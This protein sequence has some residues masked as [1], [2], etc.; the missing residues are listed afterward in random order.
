MC[1]RRRVVT[2]DAAQRVQ[3]FGRRPF[4]EREDGDTLHGCIITLAGIRQDWQC[5]VV[6]QFAKSFQQSNTRLRRDVAAQRIDNGRRCRRL[7]F[8]AFTNIDDHVL[9][10]R[11]FRTATDFRQQVDDYWQILFTGHER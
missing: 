10:L 9:Q 1:K 6:G 7:I 11:T 5:T 4:T 3:R 2:A 8:C